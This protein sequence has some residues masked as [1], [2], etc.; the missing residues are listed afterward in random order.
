MMHQLRAAD[1]LAEVR[2]EIAR[3]RLRERQL[4]AA[5]LHA[6]SAERQ[7]RWTRVEVTQLLREVFDPALLPDAVRQDPRY[8]R[9]AME[10]AVHCLPLPIASRQPRPGWPIRR[11]AA[12]AH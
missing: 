9:L 6:P 8:L 1:E 7:G 3:L 11:D 10:V 4:R 2:T 5:L 12:V